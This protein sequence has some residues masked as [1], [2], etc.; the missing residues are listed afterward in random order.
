M[1]TKAIFLLGILVSD[2]MVSFDY[3]RLLV[4]QDPLVISYF[5]DQVLSLASGLSDFRSRILPR[6]KNK[7]STRPPS[8]TPM[9]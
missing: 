3:S 1:Q 5:D 2:L 6:Q 4:N 9:T 8:Y 7:S